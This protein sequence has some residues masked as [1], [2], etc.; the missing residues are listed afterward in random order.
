MIYTYWFPGLE[1]PEETPEGCERRC[2]Y[3]NEW[4]DET[5]EPQAWLYRLRRWPATELEKAALW[6]ELHEIDEVPEGWEVCGFRDASETPTFRL[7]RTGEASTIA[8]EGAFYLRVQ[9][10]KV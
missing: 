5:R 6:M 8:Y 3:S 1:R 9:L 2:I 7:I 4:A 10:Q